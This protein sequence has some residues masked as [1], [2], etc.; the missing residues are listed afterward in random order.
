LD[1][2]FVAIGGG[3]LIAGVA[4]YIKSLKPGVQI[5]GVEPTGANAMA[6]SLAKG[7]RVTLS[8]VDAFA[9]GVAVKHVGVGFDCLLVAGLQGLDKHQASRPVHLCMLACH[10]HV[11]R[12]Y[13]TCTHFLCSACATG[14]C[15]D[16]PPVPFPHTT[17]PHHTH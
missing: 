5:I 17:N 7:A 1:A 6:M 12:M 9:D 15:G 2:V 3:G 8:R 10:H 16:V 14:G 11:M 4:A 13:T